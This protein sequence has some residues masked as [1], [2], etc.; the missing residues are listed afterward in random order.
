M[1]LNPSARL[2]ACSDGCRLSCRNSRTLSASQTLSPTMTTRSARLDCKHSR[3]SKLWL[4]SRHRPVCRTA[5]VLQSG[6][7]GHTISGVWPIGLQQDAPPTPPPPPPPPFPFSPVSPLA[8]S[9]FPLSL[10][11]LFLPLPELDQ[12]RPPAPLLWH[13]L[14]HRAGIK[15]SPPSPILVRCPHRTRIRATLVALRFNTP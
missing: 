15:V 7:E 1:S 10:P 2:K 9:P 12:M 11:P 3:G 13:L 8:S 4:A 5:S 6:K 14:P